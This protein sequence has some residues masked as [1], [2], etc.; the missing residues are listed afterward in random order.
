MLDFL[1]IKLWL[2]VFRAG[3][4]LRLH[5]AVLCM[6]VNLS[7]TPTEQPFYE[8]VWPAEIALESSNVF[9]H[10]ALCNAPHRYMH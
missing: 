1:T 3:G 9:V 8:A 6:I 7:V 2:H 5:H 4:L 10:D